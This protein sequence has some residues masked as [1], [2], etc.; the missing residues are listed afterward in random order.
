MRVRLVFSP[1]SALECPG[2]PAALG[3]GINLLRL[4]RRQAFYVDTW[5]SPLEKED[6]VLNVL[7]EV[8]GL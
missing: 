1:L 4:R 3:L 5:V 7:E 6:A 2:L 8:D